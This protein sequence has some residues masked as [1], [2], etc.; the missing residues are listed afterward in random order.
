MDLSV[1]PHRGRRCW[2]VML[3]GAACPGPAPKERDRY[4]LLGLLRGALREGQARC[5]GFSLGPA[6]LD[7]LLE[8][9]DPVPLLEAL[10][11][12]V[13]AYGRYWRA[14]YGPRR[15]P[16]R[17]PPRAVEAPAEA[18]WDLLAWIE[19]GPVRAGQAADAA[20]WR[21]SSA[22]LH[23]G[24]GKAYLP[25]D[26]AAWR[27]RWDAALWR[28][29]LR[30]SASDPRALVPVARL[31][32]GAKP[33]RTAAAPVAPSAPAGLFEEPLRSARAAAGL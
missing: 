14:W 16:F 11:R 2:L 25:V 5:E 21:W 4:V 23:A 17:W 31:L 28:E 7:L 15:R 27:R 9:A 18:R 22:P 33:F 12:A 20:A 6:G 29:R 32:A 26:T 13:T 10:R 8:T 19:T 1:R 30:E 24:T 3:R